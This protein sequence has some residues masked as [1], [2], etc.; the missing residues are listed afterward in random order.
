MYNFFFVLFYCVLNNLI[1]ILSQQKKENE[2]QDW[3]LTQINNK[4]E[5]KPLI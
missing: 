4:N 3:V 1:K 5:V 2:N